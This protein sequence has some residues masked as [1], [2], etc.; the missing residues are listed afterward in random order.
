MLD[1][2]WSGYRSANTNYG[3]ISYLINNNSIE[4]VHYP[5]TI[6][7][8]YEH[9]FA[10]RPPY[11]LK[12]NFNNQDYTIINVHSKCC[13]DGILENNYWDEEYRRLQSN[14]Y[15]KQYIDTYFFDHSV[16]VLGD[17]ND[18]IVEDNVNN[19][20]LDFIT[21]EDNY[22]F[23]DTH[24][25]SG[26]SSEWSFPN[27]PSHLDH[28]L[29]TNELFSSFDTEDVFTFKVDDYMDGW[30][31]YDYYISDHRPIVF[32]ISTIMHGDINGDENINILDITMLIN[33]ILNNS[34]NDIADLNADGGLNIL[35][36]VIL[37]NLI[38]T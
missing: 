26:P 27:W 23:A 24:I 19:V 18:D 30:Q 33:M 11:V 35:D 17:F 16:I 9:Y 22:F 20:F 28:I 37:V 3:E 14:Y 7:S 4:I 12:I 1:G 32:N 38:L 15:L 31:Q 25:A 8:E 13:G 6:L 21:D 36:V 10:Y 2:D 29:I 5:Y 34:Y